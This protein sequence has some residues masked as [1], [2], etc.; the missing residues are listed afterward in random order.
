MT[1]GGGKRRRSK[2]SKRNKSKRSK[3]PSKRRGSKSKR[4]KR[5]RQKK[6]GGMPYL[7][8]GVA[9]LGAMAATKGA[10]KLYSS[11][12]SAAGVHSDWVNPKIEKIVPSMSLEAF[13]DFGVNHPILS[14]II[15]MFGA[16]A[17]YKTFTSL[18]KE[19]P[20]VNN[21][22]Q[23]KKVKVS[24]K[25]RNQDLDINDWVRIR[26]AYNNLHKKVSLLESLYENR[27][28]IYKNQHNL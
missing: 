6:K 11:G 16:G 18:S 2:G 22:L 7:A 15:A 5:R 13:K 19:V 4:V 24:Y 20:A 3:R 12:L 9:G 8:S 26:D 10:A 1:L 17:A 23:P 27:Q 28:T 14:L 21:I 25:G